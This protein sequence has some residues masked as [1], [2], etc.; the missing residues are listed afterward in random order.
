MSAKATQGPAPGGSGSSALRPVTPAI[1]RAVVRH[2][3][4]DPLRNDFTYRTF[5]WFVDLDE[6]PR[7]PR[8]L[9]VLARFESRDHMGDPAVSLRANV[10]AFLA[11]RGIDLGGGRIT[12]LTNARMLG[13]VFNPLTVYWCHDAAGALSCVVAEVHNTYHGRHCYLLRTDA[14]GLA[15][16]DKE[17][18]VSPFYGVDGV[19][20]MSLSEPADALDLTITLH[21]A[22]GR[23]FV[24]TLRGTASPAGVAGLLQTC[25][26]YPVETMRVSVRIR[27]Q[28]IRLFLRGL[29]VIPR[30][31]LRSRRRG[32]ETNDGPTDTT[33]P[34]NAPQDDQRVDMEEDR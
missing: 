23:T 12:M 21:P 2:V 3:R 24:A 20:R 16:A 30:P 19:Y 26:R 31:G 7:F 14:T 9:R 29:P 6:L 15:S 17:F 1:Y 34:D 8:P 11:E 28:G 22:Q 5:Q 25:L 27:W 4:T 10:E 18:Y 33:Q 13:W 32:N